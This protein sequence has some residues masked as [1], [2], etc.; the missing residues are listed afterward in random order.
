MLGGTVLDV[1][2]SH[3]EP[4]VVSDAFLGRVMSRIVVY[5]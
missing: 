1:C 5:V 3:P 4:T 2:Q